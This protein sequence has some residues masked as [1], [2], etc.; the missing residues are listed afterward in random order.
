MKRLPAL[1]A[2][3]CLLFCR[4]AYAEGIEELP[5]VHGPASGTLGD[6][7]TINVPA[8][9]LYLDPAGAREF[10]RLTENPNPDH[11][12]YVLASEDL[13]W[14]AFFSYDPVGYVKD[15]EKLDADEL[16]D[17]VTEGTEESNKERRSNGWEQIHVTGW[18]FKPQYDRG[19]KSLE[20]A[21]RLKGEH[22]EGESVNYN[23]RLLG[24]RGVMEVLLLTSPERLQASVTDFKQQLPGFAFKPGESYADFRPGDQV[25][26][27]G[28]AA[29]V[30]GG[31]VVA[32]SK[33]GF[34]AAI[35]L[36]LAKAWKLAL[37]GV[38]AAGAGIRKLFARKDKKTVE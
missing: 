4:L 19:I 27:Y 14:V 34:F 7:A 8:G 36:F 18:S 12:E 22:S 6:E 2:V 10:N 17:S 35:A 26:Q 37:V 11:D 32:A 31:A 1:V 13:S 30:T 3:L 5:W 9:Y 33:K 29:L 23:T 16:L 25:A 21:F 20:W 24:R 28:L 15:D 38:A